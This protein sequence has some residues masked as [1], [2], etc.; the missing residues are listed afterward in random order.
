[1]QEGHLNVISSMRLSAPAQGASLTSASLQKDSIAITWSTGMLQVFSTASHSRLPLQLLDSAHSEPQLL[2]FR[3]LA[4][5]CTHRSL[6]DLLHIPTA[7]DANKASTPSRQSVHGSL[8]NGAVKALAEASQTKSGKKSKSHKKKRK[9]AEAAAEAEPD[10]LSHLQPLPE[11]SALL[12]S[13]SV[14]EGSVALAS[15]ESCASQHHA[16]TAGG[17]EG[18]LRLSLFDTCYGGIQQ[19]HLVEGLQPPSTSARLQVTMTIHVTLIA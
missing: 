2:S 4:V 3:Q 18:S 1:M 13:S 6:P 7:L 16:Q 14:S 5:T 10:Q 8:P 19:S 15:W 9:E 12:A 17:L 11:G